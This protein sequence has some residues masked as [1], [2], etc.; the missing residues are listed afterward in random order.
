MSF[1][2]TIIWD[3]IRDAGMLT[4]ASFAL[5][6]STTLTIDVGIEQP[7]ELVSSG[8][9]VSREYVIE[10][11]TADLPT[12]LLVASVQAIGLQFRPRGQPRL[13]GDGTFAKWSLTRED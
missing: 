7:D 13:Q 3:A 5:T 2:A 12:P 10:F 11:P 1:D 6:D 8:K 4:P 9:G